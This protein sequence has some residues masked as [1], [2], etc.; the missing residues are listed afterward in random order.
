V[1]ITPEKILIGR[2]GLDLD[3]ILSHKLE[4]ILDRIL[5]HFEKPSKQ[6]L[7]GFETRS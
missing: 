1:T 3:R 4:R 7:P 6:Q 5:F 2:Y